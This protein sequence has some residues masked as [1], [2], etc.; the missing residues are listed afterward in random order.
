MDLKKVYI[1]CC[2]FWNTIVISAIY[3]V[4]FLR[5]IFILFY[6]IASALYIEDIEGIA[7]KKQVCGA[8]R[9]IRSV[10][11]ARIEEVPRL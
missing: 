7:V 2:K 11:E 1:S 10:M 8:P 6:I 4:L 3:Q 5:L 9:P